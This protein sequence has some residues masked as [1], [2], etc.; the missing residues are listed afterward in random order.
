M[1][2][3]RFRSRRRRSPSPGRRLAWR[4]GL[5]V[6]VLVSAWVIYLDLRIRL[7]FEQKRWSLPALVYARPL[8]LY[9]GLPLSADELERTLRRLHYHAVGRV[10]GPGQYHRQGRRLTLQTRA[11]RFPDGPEA[12]RRLRLR[13]GDGRLLSLRPADGGAAPGLVRLDPRRIASIYPAR[14]ADRILLRLDQV[15]PLLVAAFIAVEDRDFYHHHGLSLRGI[16][17]ALLADIRA[18]ALVQ[19]GSTLT[20]QLV[21]NLF[22]DN[23]RS[24]WRKLNEAAMAL[25]LELHYD[26]RAILES[27]LN[28][29]YLGQDGARAIHGVGLASRFYFDRPL[30]ALRPEQLALLV[31]MVRG[32]SYYDPRRH[33]G[34]ARARRNR[35]LRILADQGLITAAKARKLARR[36]LGLGPRRRQVTNA[37]PGFLELVRAQLRR[38]YREQDLTRGGLRIFTTLDTRVQALAMQRLA[39]RLRRIER[40]HR[41]PAGRLQGALVVT[42]TGTGEIL[43]LVPGRDSARAGFNR[44]LHARRQVGSLLKPAL[45]LEAL[46]HPDRFTLASVLEDRPL[47]V[48]LDDGRTWSPRNDDGRFHG[49]VLLYRALVRSENVPT[50][51]LGL[52]LG[53][54]RLVSLLHR[55]GIESELPAYPS[56]FL[57]AANLTP[58]EVTRLYQTLAAGGFRTPLRTIRAVLDARGRALRRYP[59]EV[60]QV[61]D[62]PVMT[63]IQWTLQRVVTEGTA[64]ALGRRF[65]PALGMAGKT[66]TTNDLRDSWFAGFSGNRLAVVWV[67][68]DDDGPMGLTG[69]A[70]AG[71]VF[72]DLMSRLPLEPLVLSDQGLDWAWIDPASG[73]LAGPG[74]PGRVRLPFL[75][76]SVPDR[77]APCGGPATPSGGGRRP[78]IHWLQRLW[79]EVR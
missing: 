8:E 28:E 55:L 54:D 21:K 25:L 37:Y 26:K 12:S 65:D 41:L 62:G 18:R 35:V 49:R 3:R 42:D 47:R 63:L 20:Q 14:K 71:A 67:G 76:G 40:R 61:V 68:R 72:A 44:V 56:L 23:R 16:A 51:R 22:F 2:R 36:P 38:D 43:A 59:L 48:Q 19:G 79:R 58:L 17:R 27:Y 60:K 24:F 11:F 52:A 34:R 39:D 57:G 70:G 33:P 50:V 30:R 74:C 5:V 45:Y 29:V 69:A 15:P 6:L 4:L 77:R 13:F 46:R 78:V 75:A 10:R 73:G 64:R 32:P 9:A 7:Q 53:V 31:G 66:G 1:G